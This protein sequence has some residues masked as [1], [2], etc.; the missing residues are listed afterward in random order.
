MSGRR[1][2][3]RAV[4]VSQLR[5]DP[6]TIAL[7]LLVPCVLER[8]PLRSSRSPPVF[9]RVGVP[10]LG[11][12]PFVSMFLVTSVTMLRE[13]MTGTLERLMTLPL[14]KLD[15]LLG[16]G[17]AFALLA[18]VQAR[19]LGASGSACSASTSQARTCVVVGLAIA[20]ALLGMS[21]GLF[22]ARSPAPS[23]RRS[24]SCP[25]SC[26]RRSCSAASSCRA[27]RWRRGW[28]DLRGACRS[29]TPT[30]RSPACTRT[31]PWRPL[32]GSTSRH[33]RRDAARARARRRD[34]APENAL[35]FLTA[36][37]S[38]TMDSLRRRRAWRSSGRSRARCRCRRSRGHRALDDDDARRLVDVEDGHP[39]DRTGGVVT[40]SGIRDVVRADDE[41]DVCP[42]ELGVHVLH[43]EELRVRHVRLGEEHV[44]VAWHTTGYRVDR[45]L[46][47]DALLLEHVGE[48]RA[49]RAAPARP[50]A[51]SPGRYDPARVREHH[52]DIVRG[53]RADGA[54]VDARAP[55][56]LRPGPSRT[57]RRG[58]SRASGSSPGPSGSSAA[59]PKHRPVCR[60]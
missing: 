18:V 36:A 35:A 33:D 6:R 25:R 56:R 42:R 29:R 39:V 54:A 48:L 32:R 59:F 27:T 52:S 44:H 20:N 55:A 15:L 43:L 37:M 57:H 22:S 38:F 50:Q 41:R 51:R 30:T 46:D 5:R 58:R 19:R 8:P 24:S 3:Q 49:R 45:V 16:Y 26:S 28:R 4:R 7:I 17:I 34:P 23:S 10:M 9:E 11:I 60:R 47:L 53:R 40:G 2:A 12:F 13:R 31:R 14:A 1:H 21:L